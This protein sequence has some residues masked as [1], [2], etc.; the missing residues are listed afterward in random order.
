MTSPMAWQGRTCRCSSASSPQTAKSAERSTSSFS[1]AVTRA[2]TSVPR[3]APTAGMEDVLVSLCG[4]TIRWTPTTIP[5]PST[6]MAPV[7]QL[8]GALIPRRSTT[9][10]SRWAMTAPAN[11]RVAR[12]ISTATTRPMPRWTTEAVP[13]RRLARLN[14]DGSIGALELT[15]AGVLQHRRV[16]HPDPI[17]LEDLGVDACDLPG[18]D[19]RRG[20]YLSQCNQ[21]RSRRNRGGWLLPLDWLHGSG[22][23]ELP[24]SGQPR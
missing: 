7:A 18:A 22:H 1:L 13:M 23:A 8:R 2:R 11:S 19:C 10:R 3:S 16:W 14:E 20:M 17:S 24:A 21:L 6:T 4:C 15:A 9:I 12:W 5:A